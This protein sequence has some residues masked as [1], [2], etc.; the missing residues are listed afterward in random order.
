MKEGRVPKK[1]G[2]LLVDSYRNEDM[3]EQEFDVFGYFA[4]RILVNVNA[5][6]TKYEKLKYT[7]LLSECFTYTDEAFALL[8]LINYEERW[9]SQYSNLVRFPDVSSGERK[10]RTFQA[11]YTSATEGS[12]RGQSWSKEGLEKFNYLCH[13]IRRKRDHEISGQ[14]MEVQ[15]RHRCR[16]EGNLPKFVEEGDEMNEIDEE[17]IEEDDLNVHVEGDLFGI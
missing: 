9:R 10:N 1:F 2:K 6:N 3:T 4:T 17:N 14:R 11:S 5:I 13:M 15:L 8:V 12:R 7:K 16:Q